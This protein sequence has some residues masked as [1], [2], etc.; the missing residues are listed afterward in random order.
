MSVLHSFSWLTVYY[1]VISHFSFSTIRWS[2]G[3][4]P[5]LAIWL[6]LPRTFSHHSWIC[7]CVSVSVS[8]W[9]CSTCVDVR[10]QPVG[11]SSLLPPRRLQGSDSGHKG[12][13]TCA[14]TD[15]TTLPALQGIFVDKFLHRQ[16]FDFLRMKAEMLGHMGY[17]LIFWKAAKLSAF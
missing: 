9:V 12:L 4:F 15:W 16:C 11:V 6:I 8:T 3:L 17:A 10:G 7:L 1:I 2:V 13:S 5:L 14:F